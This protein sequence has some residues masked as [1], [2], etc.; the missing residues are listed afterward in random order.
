MRARLVFDRDGEV[1]LDGV[2]TRLGFDG[3][4]FVESKASRVQAIGVWLMPDDVWWEGKL[5]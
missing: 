3:A 4:I 1:W 5:V 2:A